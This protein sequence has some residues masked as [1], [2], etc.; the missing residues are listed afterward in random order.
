MM[1]VSR[2][3]LTPAS[4]RSPCAMIFPE[5][6]PLI[7]TFLKPVTLGRRAQALLIRC[8]VAFLMH[9][10]KMS[11]SQAAGAIRT[12]ARHRA[13][14]SRFLGR[15]YWK[16][17]DLLGPLRA[18]LLEREA[19]Q[20]GTFLFTVDQTLCGSQ[21]QRNENTFRCGNYRKRPRKSQRRQTKT[22]RR[23]AHCFV[24]GLL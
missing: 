20:D 4:R 1:A 23:S 13:Q 7:K 8:L 3:P 12:D 19:Q 2:R 18:A 11:A 16:R 24:M 21:A 10:G 14:I 15:A 17:T 9:L 6:L 5:A 22:E